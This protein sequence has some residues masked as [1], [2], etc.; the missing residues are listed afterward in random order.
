MS[1]AAAFLRAI[2]SEPADDTARLAFADFLEETGEPVH[3]ARADFIRKQITAHTLHPNDPRR[4]ELEGRAAAL[5]ADHWIDW[6]SPVCAAVGLPEPFVPT[7]S[8]RERFRRFVG[9]PV[10]ARRGYPYGLEGGTM[11]G[12]QRPAEPAPNAPRSVAFERGFPQWLS[13]LG[14]SSDVGMVVRRWTEAAPLTS[15]ILHGTVARDWRLIDGEHLRGVREIGLGAAATSALTAVAGS[16][17][18]PR[19]EELSLRPDRS[20]VAWPA[21]QYRAFSESSLA[22]RV[23]WLKVVIGTADEADALDGPH[24][25]NLRVLRVEGDPVLDQDREDVARVAGA[26]RALLGSR[27]L[28]GLKELALTGAACDAVS[29]LATHFATSLRRLTI[30]SAGAVAVRDAIRRDTF[31]ALTDLTLTV[32]S[33]MGDISAALID[34]PLARRLRHLSLSGGRLSE[35]DGQREILQLVQALDPER[36][37]TLALDRRVRDLPDVW[38]EL[39]A[40]FPGR[41]SL[42]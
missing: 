32:T 18:L 27:H 38:D 29:R 1:D 15:L 21:E 12:W 3:V 8:L 26:A 35:Q 16:R 23:K 24:L 20:N 6:W 33:Q 5:F 13:L 30:S 25:A 2:A 40:R 9:L 36:L 39:Q 11:I 42:V 41:V 14:Q 19:L 7:G 31:P 10:P 28:T 34:S 22:S 17:H 37:E 4:A